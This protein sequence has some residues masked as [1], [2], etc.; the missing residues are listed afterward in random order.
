MVNLWKVKRRD[1]VAFGCSFARLFVDKGEPAQSHISEYDDD[2]VN[3]LAII[4]DSHF[5]NAQHCFTVQLVPLATAMMLLVPF[6]QK[7]IIGQ[8]LPS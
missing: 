2:D 3:A 4:V 1:L 5:L 7:V 6:Q 8:Y